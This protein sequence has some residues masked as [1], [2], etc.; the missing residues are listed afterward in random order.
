MKR[1]RKPP[2]QTEFE[3]RIIYFMTAKTLPFEVLQD[4]PFEQ[5]FEGRSKFSQVYLAIS[6]KIVL[7]FQNMLFYAYQLN[8]RV[9]HTNFFSYSTQI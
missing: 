1:S 3:N 4:G 8:T 5:L 2:S 7:H 6:K 9:S